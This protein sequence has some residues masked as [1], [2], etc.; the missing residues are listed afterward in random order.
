[1]IVIR[2]ITQQDAEAF[3]Q[4]AF[5]AGIG[6]TSMPKNRDVLL[7]R[8]ANSG[9][10][11][12]KQ[13]KQPGDESYLFVLEDINTGA[14][15]GTSGIVAKTGLKNPLYFYRIETIQ[16]DGPI[17]PRAID[18]PLMK[19]VHYYNAPSEIC[20]LYLS[21]QFR[22]EGLGR[23]LSLARFLF[24]AEFPERFDQTIFAE[25]RGYIE[26]DLSSPFWEGIGRHFI[27]IDF[28]SLMHMRDE[29]TL[30]VSQILP[31]Y[32]IYLS[33]LPKSVQEGIGKIHPATR[34][35]LNMLIQ[36]GFY[37]TEDIDV[38]D[39]G[40]KIEAE[41]KDIRTIKSSKV[42]AVVEI[43]SRPIEGPR[44]ILSNNRL[45]FRACYSSLQ[46]K[47]AKGIAIPHATA[48]ALKLQVGDSIRYAVPSW[49]EEQRIKEQQ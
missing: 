18:I 39:G 36:E 45:D 1:M 12:K 49:E 26:K 9:S 4:I 40:P 41:I 13:L 25:M 2:P 48:E 17:Y 28:T 14:I 11:F 19:V 29:E 37:H 43:S 30:D 47:G 16:Q 10:S 34:P 22:Q 32:P 31:A 38:F 46:Y 23:L 20:S 6:M 5:E 44:Y 33:L 42:D 8:V 3:I 7:E 21:P 15:G 35:A 27:D 24:I